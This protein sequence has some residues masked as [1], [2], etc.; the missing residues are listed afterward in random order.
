MRFAVGGRDAYAYT[1]ARAL[2][3]ARPTVVFVHG[4]GNDHSVWALQSRYFA[5]HGHNVLAVDLPAHGRT[6][7]PVQPTVE[8][9]AAWLGDVLDALGVARCALV[10]HSLGALSALALAASRPSH[11]HRL[12]LLGPAAPMTVSDALLDAA[13]HDEPLA[14]A[15]ITGWSHAPAHQLGGNRAPGMWMTGQARQLLARTP[16][17][18]LHADLLACHRYADVT[19]AASAVRCPVLLVLGAR[20]VMAP[21]RQA[22]PLQAALPAAQTVTL[23]ATGHAMMAEAPD[24]VLDALRAFLS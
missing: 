21:P 11:V 7:G 23:P 24:D 6:A 14:A 9:I 2:D 8:A 22:A 3:P 17:G 4:A 5:H 18:V 10:G 1:G 16:P 12:A 19:S 13:L 15:L 20:D